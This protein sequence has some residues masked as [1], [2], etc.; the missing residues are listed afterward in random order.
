MGH[1]NAF[2]VAIKKKDIVPAIDH[3]NSILEDFDFSK[4]HL[5]DYEFDASEVTSDMVF[6]MAETKPFFGQGMDE[7]RV[8]IKNL[9]VMPE[10]ADVLGRSGNTFKVTVNGVTYLK[11]G[12]SEEEI[13]ALTFTE[14]GAIINI[15]CKPSI[16]EFN[17]ELNA[18]CYIDEI[19]FLNKE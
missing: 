12:C 15:V 6:E 7:M 19:E 8:V 2:G 4:T 10:D 13:D 9:V 1:G 3:M 18:Q 16:N 17:G 5:V 14:N 11:F